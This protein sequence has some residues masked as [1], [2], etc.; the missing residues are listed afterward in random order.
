M[1]RAF[2]ITAVILSAATAAAQMTPM[3]YGI[4]GGGVMF[5]PGGS[6]LMI[7]PVLIPAE[8]GGGG[9]CT[10][11]LDFSQACNSQYIGVIR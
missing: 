8:A 3:W 4:P 5:G 10:N 1:I 11:S 6:N 7:G 9:G 2:I